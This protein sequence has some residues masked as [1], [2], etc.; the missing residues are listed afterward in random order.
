MTQ[1]LLQNPLENLYRDLLDAA[2]DAMIVVDTDGRIAL[3]NT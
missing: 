1:Q 2:P 3:A